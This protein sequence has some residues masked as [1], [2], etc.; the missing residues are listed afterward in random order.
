VGAY[1]VTSLPREAGPAGNYRYAIWKDGQQVAE[2]RHDYRGD[3]CRIS[4]KTGPWIDAPFIL[5]GRG[6]DPWVV[7]ETGA[8]F[9]DAHLGEGQ[10]ANSA[11]DA[12]GHVE[13]LASTSSAL[14]K[15]TR[16]RFALWAVT[17]VV[18]IL[19]LWVAANFG[20]EFSLPRLR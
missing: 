5:S 4:I 17:L 6:P 16:S 12:K 19:A 18:T 10:G 9:L 2:F 20:I 11:R 7:T 14:T 3:E 1:T 8:R 13:D 15:T